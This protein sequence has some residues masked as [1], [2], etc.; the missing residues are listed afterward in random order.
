MASLPRQKI[1]SDE[2]LNKVFNVIHKKPNRD[3]IKF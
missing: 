2:N 3:Y 1:L